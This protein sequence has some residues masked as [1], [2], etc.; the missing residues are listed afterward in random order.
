MQILLD[1]AVLFAQHGFHATSMREICKAARLSA[2]AM[3]H[4]FASKDDIIAGLIALD[5]QRTTAAFATMPEGASLIQ[6]L[7]HLTNVAGQDFGHT[8]LLRMWTEITAEVARNDAVRK[9]FT[10]YYHEIHSKLT[11][12][13][14]QSLKRGELR[15]ELKPADTA[16]FIMA[17][18]DGIMCR[19]AVH[20]AGDFLKQSKTMLGMI[21]IVLDEKG[22][23]KIDPSP[24]AS[25]SRRSKP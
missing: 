6:V 8:G 18:Y 3:Y 16:T 22:N 19:C 7:S 9:H 2:G 4:Y 17:V 10:D 1:A 25:K 23:Q 12:L 21:S 14:K 11:L 20:N 13:L 15:P 24:T 5:R